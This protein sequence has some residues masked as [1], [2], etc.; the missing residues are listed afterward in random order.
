MDKPIMLSERNRMAAA[1]AFND[2]LLCLGFQPDTDPHFNGTADR[3]VKMYCEE[4]FVGSYTEPPKITAFDDPDM[5]R[6]SMTASEY[7]T[8]EQVPI[9]EMI[10][11]GPLRVR[12]TC[13]HHML[14][15]TG[16]AHV[17]LILS[18]DSMLPGLSKYGRIV[19]YFASRPQVQ[20]RLT[21]QI[22]DHLQTELKPDGLG[23]M[24]RAKHMC[25]CHRGM[26]Q[27]DA[28]MVTTALR[29]VFKTSQAVRNEF[30]ATIQINQSK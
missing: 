26:Q 4:L 24:V 22:A 28:Q 11:S 18:A 17:A 10:Y 13:S 21:K 16:E 14:P 15:I 3:V 2:F 5:R 27:Q 1:A 19:D 12:S 6:N 25:Q 23:V 7:G 8:G 29:G 9:D 20:E 30:L